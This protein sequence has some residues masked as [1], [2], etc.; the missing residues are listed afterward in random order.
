M[1]LVNL[2]LAQNTHPGL[3]LGVQGRETEQHA[4]ENFI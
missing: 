3:H 4:F 2:G 1:K